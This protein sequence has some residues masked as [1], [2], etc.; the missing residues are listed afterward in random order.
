[1]VKFYTAKTKKNPCE[2]LAYLGSFGSV[3]ELSFP[4]APYRD[5]TGAGDRRVQDNLHAHAQNDYIFLPKSREKP[6]LEALSRFGL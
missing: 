1:M 6:Y 2:I 4:P 5:S 3:P